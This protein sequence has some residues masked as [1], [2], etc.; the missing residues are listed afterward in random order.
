MKF[1]ML[2]VW[3]HWEVRL[4]L[5]RD[6]K[7]GWCWGPLRRPWNMC[8][9]VNAMC[10][11]PGCNH[12]KAS[13]N[14]V[15]WTCPYRPE[16]RQK[17]SSGLLNRYGWRDH[18]TTE[19]LINSMSNKCGKVVQRAA[20]RASCSFASVPATSDLVRRACRAESTSWHYNG[21]RHSDI[22][23]NM[24][25]GISVWFLSNISSGILSDMPSDTFSDILSDKSSDVL[26]DISSDIP[27]N[28]LS[29]ISS[30]SLS[31][32]YSD[33]LLLVE[34]HCSQ[35]IAVEVRQPTLAARL[36]VEVRQRTLAVEVP[37]GTLQAE[38][39]GWGPAG[40][41]GS[42][43]SLLKS[44]REHRKRGIAE[45]KEEEKEEQWGS[46]NL[47]SSPDGWGKKEGMT[48]SHLRLGNFSD[49]SF[50][51]ILKMSEGWT[52]CINLAN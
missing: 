24:L 17:S 39:R 9:F 29:G 20:R 6:Q 18:L 37:Q 36:A 8:E 31:G 11:N 7:D 22:P 43:G 40:N 1:L 21:V 13:W 52:T 34:V 47:V 25:S 30:Y 5:L 12:T 14:H 46:K 41:T 44:C 33:I 38:D 49:V 32:I 16:V 15:M 42:R 3:S 51:G 4:L 10:T 19:D 26:F 35:M 28:I 48:S 2:N 45:E 23:Y 27:S 50:Q